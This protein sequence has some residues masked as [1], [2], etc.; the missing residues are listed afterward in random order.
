MNEFVCDVNAPLVA[1]AIVEPVGELRGRVEIEHIHVEFALL[2]KAREREIAGAEKAGDRIVRVGA[3]AKVELGV[4]RVPQ[5][6]LHYYLAIVATA[7]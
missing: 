6:Q 5:M 2:G 4:K 7:E 1:P 3:K